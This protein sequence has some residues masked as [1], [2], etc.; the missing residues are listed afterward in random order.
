M[1]APPSASSWDGGILQLR[2][3]SW[4]AQGEVGVPGPKRP[5][6]PS[7]QGSDISHQRPFISLLDLR[8]LGEE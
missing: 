6:R 8:D 4:E 5:L 3:S 2:L 1:T 7:S